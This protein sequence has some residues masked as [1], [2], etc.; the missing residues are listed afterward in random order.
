[1]ACDS[2][3][4]GIM[5][6]QRD[7]RSDLHT[8]DVE[9]AIFVSKVKL[10]KRHINSLDVMRRYVE[11]SEEQHG[12]GDLSMEPLRLIK[13]QYAHLGTEPSEDVSA[14]WHDDDHGIH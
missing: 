11:D 8:F 1:V 12:V 7:L 14:H 3:S 10:G 4:L 9:E 5:D 2:T 13:R 6:L